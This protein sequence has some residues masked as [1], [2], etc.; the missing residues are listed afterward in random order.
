MMHE[1]FRREKELAILR[2]RIATRHSFLLHGP[3]G[4]GKTMLIRALLPELPEVLYCRDASG[5][6]RVLRAIASAL[7]ERGA[8]A[9]RVLGGPEG[10]RTKSA[11]S[12]KGIVQDLLR[13]AKYWVVLDHLQR[14]SQ[15][16][17]ADIK[18]IAGWAMTPV[19]GIARSDHMEDVG[20]LM[21]LF[22]DRSEKVELHNFDEVQ[23]AEFA[24][25]VAAS[26][27]L[28]A[29]NAAEFMSRVVELS[30]GNPGAIAAMVEMGK[31]PKYR[32]G[33]QIMVSPLYIDFRLNWPSAD[34]R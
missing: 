30:H 23:A 3:A 27:G 5:K 16:F 15:A 32:A 8:T 19:L 21:A 2:Q 22:S 29:S 26:S 4:V 18:E 11:V 33:E 20:F 6:Q 1:L 12:L 13:S 28:A 31:S 17:A 7:A 34:F 10:I 25:M 14:P 9:T 24:R